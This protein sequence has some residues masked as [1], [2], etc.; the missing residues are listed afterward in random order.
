MANSIHA[1]DPPRRSIVLHSYSAWRV[2]VVREAQGGRRELQVANHRKL[3]YVAQVED[4]S[5]CVVRRN[6]RAGGDVLRLSFLRVVLSPD[7][8]QA[9]R[10]ASVFDCGSR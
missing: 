7:S 2:A 1:L 10:V 6:G 8:A 5:S 3:R 9:A 4:R